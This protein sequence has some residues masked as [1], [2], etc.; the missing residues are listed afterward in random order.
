MLL[1]RKVR[2]AGFDAYVTRNLSDA[3]DYVSTRYQQEIDKRFGLLASSKGRACA[4]Y[5]INN[6]WDVTRR[7]RPGPWYN[8]SPDSST[9]C[10]QLREVAT[11]FSCQGLELDFPI[12]AW[13]EDLLWQNQNWVSLAQPRSK[14]HDPHQLRLNSYRV[15]LT[16]GRDGMAIFVPP[17]PRFD[18]TFD[19]LC[20]FGF[21][22]LKSETENDTLVEQV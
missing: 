20:R 19:A 5:G 6:S 22:K 9:S 8:D 11:E 16:R 12:L 17:E 2:E 10:C 1:G 4:G 15:L 14:A 3:V 21:R 18:T 7:F 13:N